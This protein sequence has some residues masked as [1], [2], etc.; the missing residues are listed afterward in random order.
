MHPILC[1][2][3]LQILPKD[4]TSEAAARGQGVS[5]YEELTPW[6]TVMKFK[7]NCLICTAMTISAATDG[8]QIGL[9][10]NIIANAGFIA[11]FGTQHTGDGGVVLASSVLSVWASLGSVGQIIGMVTL[12]F[13]TDRFGR[14]ISMYW[15]WLLLAISVA[16]ECFAKTWGVWTVAKVFGGIGVGCLQSTI[17]AYISEVAPVRVMLEKDPN[18]YLTPVYTQWSQIG[19][20]LIIYLLVPESPAWLASK[21]KAEQAKKSLNTIYRGVDGFDVDHQYNLLLINIEHE[22]E[23]AA[24]KNREKWYAIFRGRDGLRT[25]IS[26][27]TLMAQQFIGLG[28]FFGYA[29]YFFQQAGLRD[30][31]KITYITSDIN[32]LFSIVVIAVSDTI[33]RRW[34]ANTGTAICW[35]CCVVVG[36]LGVVPQVK[37]TNYV[38]V[39]FACIWNIGLVANGATGWGFIGEISSQRLRPYT[40]GFAAASTCVVGVVM[41]ILIPYMVNAHEWNWGLKTSWLFAGLGA[42]FTLAMWFLIPETAG[43]SAAELDELFERKIKP[44]RFH[45][46]V[47][48]TQRMVELNKEERE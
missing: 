20:M 14:K 18:D 12:P 42:P 29:T 22:R 23:I 47:T 44:W 30:P 45:K 48:A 9:I 19:L 27:W 35:V 7:M 25:V 17:P 32:I 8:Y 16:I 6:Q 15:Y 38:F 11:Q 1:I 21:G 3:L 36:I 40:A 2:S 28:I 4:L 10:G 43:R 41:G 31:F 13:I 33:G 24:E 34:L 37:A 5:G 46:T 26:C 39:L